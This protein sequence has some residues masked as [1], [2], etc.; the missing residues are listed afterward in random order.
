MI[1]RCTD[2]DIPAIEAIV[3]DAAQ[4]YRGVIPADRWHDPYMTRSELTAEIAAGVEFWGQEESGE[5]VGVMGL[6]KVRE[7]M[8]I[9]HAYV[10]PDHQGRGVGSALL[11]ALVG[12]ATGPLLVGTWAAAT[13]AIRFYERHGFRLVSKEEKDQLLDTYWTI[14]LRQRESSVV[15]AHVR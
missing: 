2:A 9:R 8:L 6:Q 1:R 7:V 5:L 11:A 12:R 4:S 10:R 15:L 3:N 14:P 13:W